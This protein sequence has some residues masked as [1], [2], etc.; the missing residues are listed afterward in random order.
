[1]R[2][3]SVTLPEI[4]QA[5]GVLGFAFDSA[6]ADKIRLARIPMMAMTTSNSIN[7]NAPR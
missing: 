6:N 5:F 1:M 2:S 7:V 3:P 4:V